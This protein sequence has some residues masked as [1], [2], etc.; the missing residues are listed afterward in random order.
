M[1]K[2]IAGFL[3]THKYTHTFRSGFDHLGDISVDELVRYHDFARIR[4][5]SGQSQIPFRTHNN[6]EKTRVGH[7]EK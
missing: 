3:S 1:T 6:D 7:L 5:D 2:D 4:D